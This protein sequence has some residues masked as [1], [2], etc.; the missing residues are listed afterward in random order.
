MNY[1]SSLHSKLIKEYTS[2][3]EK[4]FEKLDTLEDLEKFLRAMISRILKIIG[5]ITKGKIT[6]RELIVQGLK[7]FGKKFMKAMVSSKL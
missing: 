7:I 5:K 1:D 2:Q 6:R 4:V 3:I